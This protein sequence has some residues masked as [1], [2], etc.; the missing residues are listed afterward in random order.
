MVAAILSSK[1]RD[2]RDFVFHDHKSIL[3]GIGA[4]MREVKYESRKEFTR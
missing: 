4:I 2:E 3:E 1:I